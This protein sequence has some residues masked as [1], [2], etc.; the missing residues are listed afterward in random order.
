[1]KKF[2]NSIIN[3]I[4]EIIGSSL[5][6]YLAIMAIVLYWLLQSEV[7]QAPEFIYSNF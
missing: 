2:K 4:A 1:M 6:M 3:S 7:S 5:I